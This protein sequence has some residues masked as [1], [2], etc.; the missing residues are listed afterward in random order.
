MDMRMNR[1]GQDARLVG[2]FRL[3]GLDRINDAAVLLVGG[4]PPCL[5]DCLGRTRIDVD[6]ARIDGGAH[7]QAAVGELR[8]SRLTSLDVSIRIIWCKSLGS[9][10]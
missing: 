6:H 9:E 5:K 1:Q 8:T 4:V 10:R 2:Q 7:R 3:E